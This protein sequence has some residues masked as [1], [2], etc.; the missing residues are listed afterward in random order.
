MI[1]V[2]VVDDHPMFREGVVALIDGQADIRVVAQGGS[3]EEAVAL[4]TEHHPDVMLLDVEM[5]GTSIQRT[6]RR[7]VEAS[8]VTRIVVLTMHDDPALERSLL[9]R[10]A[11]EFLTKRSPAQELVEAVVRAAGSPPATF[12]TTTPVPELT[13]REKEVLGLVAAG[14]SNAAIA[15]RLFI[16]PGTVKRHLSQTYPKLGVP[17]RT[18]AVRVARLHGFIS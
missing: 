17:S 16:S 9:D 12:P 4:A 11:S 5:P 8:P 10:E 14:L 3:G 18:A 6:L 7:V 13:R 15:D 2:V 1:A